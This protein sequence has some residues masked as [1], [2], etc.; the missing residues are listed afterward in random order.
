MSTRALCDAFKDSPLIL[1]IDTS[2]EMIRMANSI[3]R[4]DFAVTFML[5][6]LSSCNPLLSQCLSDLGYSNLLVTDAHNENKIFE[7]K[8]LL[9]SCLFAQGNAERISLLPPGAFD[10]I[11]IMY[12][13]HEI[14]MSARYRILREARRLLKEGGTLAIVDIHQDLIPLPSMLMGEPYILEYLQNFHKQMTRLQGFC[15]FKHHIVIEGHVS[16]WTLTRK[17]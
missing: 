7:D 2:P 9:H 3:T 16:L 11:T 4:H 13:F 1:G 5:Q 12:A 15:N 10:I 8:H 17:V 14:P 6:S